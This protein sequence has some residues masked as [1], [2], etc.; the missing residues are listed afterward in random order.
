MPQGL[1]LFDFDAVLFDV[2]G[3]LVDSLEMIVRGLRDTYERFAGVRPSTDEI[4]LQIGKPLSDQVRLHLGS[5]PTPQQISEMSEFAIGR[6]SLYEEHESL[7]RPAVDCLRLL[8]RQG[9]RTALV[10]SKSD[11]ELC[12]FLNRF[13]GA[14]YV[15][16]TI[17]ASDVHRPKPHPESALK[18]CEI[19]GVRP[20]RAAMV[21]DSVYDLRCAKQAG[22]TA[23]AV[24]YGAGRRED[25][26]REQP[27]LLL[28]TPEELLAWAETAFLQTPCRERS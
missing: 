3:T 22:L 13:E 25:L 10:T 20:E 17:C 21:G 4:L 1:S 6:F 7:F 12:G 19:L 9:V 23:V 11:V 26:L 15:D 16:A 18:A 5:E 8:H 14:R 24:A 27:D 2:D 28:D